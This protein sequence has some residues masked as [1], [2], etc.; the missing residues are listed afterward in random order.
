MTETNFSPFPIL[1]TEH[2]ILRQLEATD[3]QDIFTHRQNE[4][5]N[6]YVD[7][8]RHASVTQSQAFIDRVLNEI[9]LGK[10]LLWV[11][12]VK[13][14]NKFIGTVCLWNI[15]W[16]EGTAETGYTVE[17]AFHGRG[18]MNEALAK[19]IEFGFNIMKLR[20]ID[21]YTHEN[22]DSSIRLLIR[23]N[24]KPGVPKKPVSS[25]RVYFCLTREAY[26]IFK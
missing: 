1:A 22:N 20:S 26:G 7:D 9:S 11:L 15:S 23:N 16:N 14:S 18:Y 12:N 8:F 6:M 2:L 19:T 13:G 10:T 4:R 5:V 25:N 24:F 3:D 17:P 21:A